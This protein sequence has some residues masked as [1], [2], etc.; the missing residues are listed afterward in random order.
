M[1]RIAWGIFLSVVL[2]WAGTAGASVVTF[3]TDELATW[4]EVAP[5]SLDGVTNWGPRIGVDFTI[6]YTGAADYQ[7]GGWN[8]INIGWS[9]DIS[10]QWYADYTGY[11]GYALSLTNA[12]LDRQ[13]VGLFMNTGFTGSG[14]ED[15]RYETDWVWVNSSETMNF[16]LPFDGVANLNHVTAIG[17]GV[18]SN[19]PNSNQQGYMSTGGVVSANPVP[20]P[21]A[22]WLLGSGLL[23]WVGLR[24]RRAHAHRA[25]S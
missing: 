24:K 21:G 11:D 13:M 9:W 12:S 5:G 7:A 18:G 16:Y 2:F 3:T 1:K 14:E 20:L 8:D 23:G 4:V 6:D 10:E 22:L 19:G 25:F 17:L 15:N